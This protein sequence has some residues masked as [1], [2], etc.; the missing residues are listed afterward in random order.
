MSVPVSKCAVQRRHTWLSAVCLQRE[1]K[2]TLNFP[3]V[4][5]FQDLAEPSAERIKALNGLLG[6][7][8]GAYLYKALGFRARIGKV[9]L[10]DIKAAYLTTNGASIAFL[11]CNLAHTFITGCLKA[12]MNYVSLLGVAKQRPAH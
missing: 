1:S 4:T 11:L 5:V 9:V 12:V 8:S 10:T 6:A 7:R 3:C 2:N